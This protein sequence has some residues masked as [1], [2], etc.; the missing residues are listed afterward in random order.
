MGTVVSMET[1]PSVAVICTRFRLDEKARAFSREG[2]GYREFIEALLANEL[3]DAA[4]D[5]IAHALPARKA[6]WWGCL[7][8]QHACGEKLTPP[9]KT[10]A[11]AAVKWVLEPTDE[12]RAATKAPAEDAGYASPAGSLA[13]AANWTGGSLGP[14][15]MPVVPPGRFMPATAAATAIKFASVKVEPIRIAGTKRLFVDLGIEVLEGRYL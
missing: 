5:F 13:R 11:A 7:C 14:P 4:I 8:L 15:E 1:L 3:P 9:D 12:N 6:V 2:I 10:A